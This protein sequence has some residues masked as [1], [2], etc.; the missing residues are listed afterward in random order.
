[1]ADDKTI[2]PKGSSPDD[3]TKTS[4]KA[5][6]ELSEEELKKASGG[7]VDAYLKFGGTSG[8]SSTESST[9]ISDVTLNFSKIV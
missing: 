4:N 6:V 1:M 5:N 3:L 8:E 9:K 7:A 2:D